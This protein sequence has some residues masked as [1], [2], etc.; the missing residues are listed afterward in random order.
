MTERRMRFLMA[1]ELDGELTELEREELERG[2]LSRPALRRERAR[3]AAVQ[4]AVSEGQPEGR[5][6]VPRVERGVLKAL[7]EPGSSSPSEGAPW[8]RALL[9]LTGMA[10]VAIAVA[11]TL[12]ATQTM[13]SRFGSGATDVPPV[14]IDVTVA[15]AEGQGEGD[16]VTLTF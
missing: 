13:G 6:M 9:V 1:R 11:L 8:P 5:L 14:S 10:A 7:R 12:D 15:E 4:A 2:L 16:V 3:W